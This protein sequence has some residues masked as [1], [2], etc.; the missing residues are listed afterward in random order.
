MIGRLFPTLRKLSNEL[1]DL[2]FEDFSFPILLFGLSY[3]FLYPQS[4]VVEAKTSLTSHSCQEVCFHASRCPIFIISSSF[5]DPN[6]SYPSI[7]YIFYSSI[8]KTQRPWILLY[9]TTSAARKPSL[10]FHRKLALWIVFLKWSAIRPSSHPSPRTRNTW[11]SP[12]A[13]LL[14]IKKALK[15]F[16][17]LRTAVTTRLSIPSDLC[18][19]RTLASTTFCHAVIL[20]ILSAVAFLSNRR[21]FSVLLVF[22]WTTMVLALAR[23]ITHFC[24]IPTPLRQLLSIHMKIS[25][26]LLS[27]LITNSTLIRWIRSWSITAPPIPIR[28]PSAIFRWISPPV[29]V[30]RVLCAKIR[31]FLLFHWMILN[32]TPKKTK[33]E[34]RR[35]HQRESHCQRRRLPLLLHKEENLERIPRVWRSMNSRIVVLFIS[36][37]LLFLSQV[38]N[39]INSILLI[40]LLLLESFIWILDLLLFILLNWVRRRLVLNLQWMLEIWRCTTMLCHL[41]SQKALPNGFPSSF[42]FVVTSKSRI[43][44]FLHV[45][46][47]PTHLS[48]LFFHFNFDVILLFFAFLFY[49]LFCSF[50]YVFLSIEESSFLIHLFCITYFLSIDL[51]LC[52]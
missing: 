44:A 51:C 42:L 8:L 10:W 52:N 35:R 20:R 13:I 7:C 43:R 41:P 6:F 36:L 37:H 1:T 19:P 40:K 11:M 48:P 34:S 29:Q 2:L 49:C 25:L 21:T 9:P 46:V 30:H 16:F 39:L 12:T 18:T 5:L 27:I 17:L 31:L 22:L 32:P 24:A 26:N 38:G 15:L 47:T 28:R 23:W 45:I 4:L 33:R 3:S 14:M 50:F